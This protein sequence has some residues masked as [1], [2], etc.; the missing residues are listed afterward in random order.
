[1]H[2]PNPDFDLLARVEIRKSP[3]KNKFHLALIGVNTL[4][5]KPEIVG[6]GLA[7]HEARTLASKMATKY[8]CAVLNIT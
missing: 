3:E 8:G 6:S 2:D 4:G 1:M 7:F 5:R